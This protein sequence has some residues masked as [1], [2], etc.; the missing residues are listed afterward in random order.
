MERNNAVSRSRIPG[1]DLFRDAE[2]APSAALR[3]TAIAGELDYLLE[4]R[5]AVRRE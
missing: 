5:D 2:V 4:T 1:Q 3:F